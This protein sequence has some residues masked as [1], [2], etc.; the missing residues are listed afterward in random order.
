MIIEQEIILEVQ[1][2]VLAM[3]LKLQLAAMVKQYLLAILESY[4][5]ILHVFV[6]KY[7]SVEGQWGNWNPWGP[8]TGACDSNAT[9][10]RTRNFTGGVKPCT[11]NATEDM[12]GCSGK[13]VRQIQVWRVFKIFSFS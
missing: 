11:G 4:P 1:C 5:Y 6:Y 2:H 10:S 3:I 13:V 12:I 9:Q 7:F 8:C